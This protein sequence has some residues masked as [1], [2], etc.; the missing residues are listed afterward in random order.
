MESL[1]LPI[2][3]AVCWFV[4]PPLDCIAEFA[5]GPVGVVPKMLPNAFPNGQGARGGASCWAP[6]FPAAAKRIVDETAKRV[7]LANMGSLSGRE[8]TVNQPV[9]S[10][11]SADP[12]V[13]V[14]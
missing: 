3:G 6:T 2:I 10:S 1:P 9:V 12:I 5:F 8:K 4:I 7:N 11:I 14:K 13:A